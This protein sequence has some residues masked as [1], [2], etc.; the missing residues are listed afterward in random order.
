MVSQTNPSSLPTVNCLFG[1]TGRPF[2]AATGL[3]NNLN[4]WYDAVTGRWLSQDPIDFW[5]GST[6][7]YCYC[8]NGPVTSEDPT[9]LSTSFQIVTNTGSA[10]NGSTAADLITALQT[11]DTNGQTIASLTAMGHGWDTGIYDGWFSETALFYVVYTPNDQKISIPA[12]GGAN[13]NGLLRRITN[14]KTRITLNACDSADLAKHISALL[15]GTKVSG[16][17]FWVWG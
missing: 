12:P 11:I 7:L 6:N 16:L 14:N 3:Q 10:Y 2:D 8:G 5:G 4:R 9:G 15:P 1:Y 17:P 13:V